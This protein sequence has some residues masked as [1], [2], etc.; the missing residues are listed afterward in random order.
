M[1]KR[2]LIINAHPK[3][4]AFCDALAQKHA[5][6]LKDSGHEVREYCLRDLDF[7][8]V[9]E[10]YDDDKPLEPDLQTLQADMQWAEH[11]VFV[12]PLWWGN[13]PGLLKGM[14]DRTLLPGFAFQFEKNRPLPK[15]L[16]KGKT[17]RLLVTMD[18]PPPL[19]KYVYGQPGHRQMKSL[20]LGFC[21]VKTLAI[22][23]YGPLA[24]AGDGMRQ[25]MLGRAYVTG[26]LGFRKDQLA[27]ALALPAGLAGAL[28]QGVKL[29]VN[30]DQNS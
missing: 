5:Q 16:L 10:G 22:D 19:Y 6:G 25:A 1:S 24:F 8:P 26:R 28:K 20:V 21:G 27:S 17:A 23:N 18:S 7:D 15:Q 9:F 12:Y 3:A 2:S 11:W 30:G 13:V 29:A 4:D 14:L